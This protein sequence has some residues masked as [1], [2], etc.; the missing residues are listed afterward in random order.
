MPR[1]SSLG[2]PSA[3]A[4]D[5]LAALHVVPVAI[6]VHARWNKISSGTSAGRSPSAYWVTQTACDLLLAYTMYY[7][8]D[9]LMSRR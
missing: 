5:R 4:G 1:D 2:L 3:G 7:K 6:V 9:D 8:H